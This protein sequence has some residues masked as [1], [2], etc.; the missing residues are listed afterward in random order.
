MTLDPHQ[1]NRRIRLGLLSAAIACLVPLAPALAEDEIPRTSSGKPDFNGH[2]NIATLTPV[3]RPP[4][5]GENQTLTPAEADAITERW[6]TNLAKDATPSDP[7]REAPPEGGV[8]IYVPEFQGA[9]GGVGGYNAF[10]VDIGD[11]TFQIDGKYRTSILVDPPNG[12]FP[13]LSD[14]GKASMKERAKFMR[15]NSGTAWWMGMDVGPYD[16]PELRPHAER[17]LMGFG[18]TAGPPALPVMYNN[19][20]RIVQTEDR[21]MILNEMNHDARIIRIDDEHDPDEIRHWLGDSV[22]R[23]E[24]DTL[25][26]TTKHFLDKPGFSQGTRDLVVEEH[27]SRIDG[28]SL[29]YKFTVTD[30]NY[31]APFSGEYVWPASDD[32]VYEYACHEGN[33]SFGGILRGARVLEQDAMKESASGPTGNG[34]SN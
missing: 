9:S 34:G 7:N 4:Q 6:A 24:G 28:E 18:S 10:Y 31:S 8:E 25:V 15:A 12:R 29:L 11:S 14:Q 32:R 19:L 21:I 5:F 3:S 16:D 13:A 2:F 26:V 1:T 33:Y 17:C 23:W 30:P 22:G 27:F 20:K